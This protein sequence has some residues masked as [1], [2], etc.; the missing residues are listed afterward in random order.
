M[1]EV[2]FHEEGKILIAR[3]QGE[4]QPR[5]VI[6][7]FPA[8]LKECLARNLDLVMGDFTRIVRHPIST[9]DLFQIGDAATIFV[10]KVKKIASL[11]RLDQH[12]REEFG[13]TVARNRGVEVREFTSLDKARAWLLK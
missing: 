11:V 3:F 2:S 1:L 8:V 13:I 6:G 7:Y 10:G 5:D 9:S 12:D 4:S